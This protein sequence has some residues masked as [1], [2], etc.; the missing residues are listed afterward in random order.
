MSRSK[1]YRL[2]LLE[3]HVSEILFRGLRR[4]FVTPVVKQTLSGLQDPLPGTV[5]PELKFPA[6]A[7]VI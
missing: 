6:L 7:P 3:Q 1:G 5:G 4:R 2:L